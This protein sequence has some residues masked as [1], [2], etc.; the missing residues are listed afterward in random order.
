[1]TETFSQDF[2]KIFL[3][4]LT[5][6]LIFHSAKKDILKL[7]RIIQ[8]KEQKKKEKQFLRPTTVF[9]RELGEERVSPEKIIKKP[10]FQL[11]PPQMMR[12]PITVELKSKPFIRPRPISKLLPIT[13][14]PILPPHLE[15]LKPIPTAGV[16]IDLFKL[17]PLIKDVGVRL[18]EANPDERVI[19]SGTMGT[20]PTNIV[21]SEEDIDRIID[22]FAQ[23]TKIPAEEGIYRVAAGNLVL[24][25]VISDITSSRFIIKKMITNPNPNPFGNQQ[26]KYP[27]LP[28]SLNMGS[29]S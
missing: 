25:A 6:E 15:Y 8:L 29:F 26:Q 5:K 17:N 23:V 1:M 10:G 18:I 16:D 20:K 9:T 13:R 24:S 4:A 2:K 3:L 12:R 11:L 19:V 7:Q 28:P 21:L 27:L 14:E 22:K